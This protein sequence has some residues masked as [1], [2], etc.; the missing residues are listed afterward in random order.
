MITLVAANSNP[1]LHHLAT[2]YE[3]ALGWMVSPATNFFEP[4]H[5]L[6]YAIDN[7]KY[8]AYSSGTEWNEDGFLNL[9]DKYR[10]RRQ[11]P[12]FIVV[13]DS[14][15]NKDE[16]LWLWDLYRPRLEKYGWKMAFVA[17][18]G[19]VPSDVPRSADLVFI[20]GSTNWKWRNVALFAAAIERVHVGRVNAGDRLE[21]CQRLGVMSV[22]GSGFFREGD[23]PRVAQL[24]DFLSGHRREAEQPR[25][26][27]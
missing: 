12:M 7:G 10:M 14:I 19:M 6:P 25:L 20:G 3:G 27:A 2:K 13:P 11:H 21:Y 5:W 18:D 23:G 24:V 4:R 22:D 17:Q 9:L 8:A 15:G 16:T 26:I 1:L